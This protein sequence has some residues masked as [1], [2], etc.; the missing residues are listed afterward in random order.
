MRTK[1]YI[2]LFF[3]IIFATNFC[4][5][6]TQ[7]IVVIDAGH[8]GKDPGA[9]GRTSNE[10]DITLA[11]ALKVGEYLKKYTDNIKVVYTR[12]SDVFIPL[13]E[14]A[15]I[16]N[17]KKAD[18][19]VSIH[20]NSTTKSYVTGTETYVMGLHKSQDNLDVAVKENS[21]IFYEDNYKKKYEGYSPDDP[22]TYIVMNLYQNAYLDWSLDLAQEIQTQFRERA[23]RKDLGVRQAGFLVLWKTT[24]PSVLIEVG[25]I[26]NRNEEIYL[27]SQYGQEIIASAIYRAI[28][29]YFNNH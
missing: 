5:S 6:Q 4:F 27:N 17:K 11:I 24:M 8:G 18:L 21:A 10:K 25:F 14:R 7:K 9:Q 28:K 23:K 22:A 3:A 16:A 20:V 12:T 15:E 1:I 26:S 13:D 19:F 2:I 29:N